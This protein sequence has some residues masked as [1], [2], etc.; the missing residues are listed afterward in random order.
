MNNQPAKLT[1][2]YINSFLDRTVGENEIGA[3]FSVIL[4]QGTEL[5]LQP[6]DV[7]KKM[8]FK[9][10]NLQIP[11]VLYNFA[12]KTSKLYW[13]DDWN[14][15]SGAGASVEELQINTNRIYATPSDLITEL[16][17]KIQA[18]DASLNFTYSDTTKRI[19]LQNNNATK[20]IRLVSSFRYANTETVLTFND[21][22]DRLGFSQ[23][24]TLSKGVIDAGSSLA[25]AG[26]L[27]MNRTNAYNLVFQESGAPHQQT[28][29]PIKNNRYRVVANV[30]VG[31]YGTLSTL[32]YISP[33]WF[34]IPI[35]NKINV[36]T[37][38]LLDDEFDEISNEYPSN[39]PIT[40]SIQFK[41]E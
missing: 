41:I 31:A 9:I 10:Y 3:K 14:D 33:E 20:K 25:G 2:M 17:T 28:I 6:N 27:L 12:P 23:D 15:V 30:P 19:T 18:K 5:G 22:N 37:Y 13:E 32:S 34:S 8:Y 36:L 26:F 29:V 16:N 39:M 35:S 4:P 1:E 11:N 21:L 40:M 24:L 38:S 7:G